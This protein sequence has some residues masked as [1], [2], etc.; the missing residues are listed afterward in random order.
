[1]AP[2]FDRETLVRMQVTSADSDYVATRVLFMTGVLP[3]AGRLANSVIESYAKAFLWSINHED[4]IQKIKEWGGNPSHDSKKILNLIHQEALIPKWDGFS[5]K[6][7]EI[8]DNCYKLYCMRYMD[9]FKVQPK[10]KADVG[11][12]DLEVID[13]ITFFLRSSIKMEDSSWENTPV[14]RILQG[15]SGA[16]GKNEREFLTRNN[17]H[18]TYEN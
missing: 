10:L 3:S 1:M 13:E 11:V 14:N 5:K 12:T 18:F 2:A 17:K 6:S 16:L 4:F 7:E 8:L 9:V 15:K